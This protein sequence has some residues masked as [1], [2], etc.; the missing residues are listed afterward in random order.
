MTR[1]RFTTFAAGAVVAAL[2]ALPVGA[3]AAG[4]SAS[5][6]DHTPAIAS[7]AKRTVEQRTTSLGKV[8]VNSEGR[9]LYLFKKD[10]RGKSACSGEC[11]KFW[12]PLRVSGKP[13]AGAGISASKLGTIRRSDGRPQV[14]YNGHPL[15]TF[16]QDTKA[17]QTHGEGL[18]AFGARWFVLSSAGNQISHK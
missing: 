2:S 9:T 7:V 3:F 14:T 10:S 16:M 8:L 5:A 15:Y 18:T 6:A 11:A 1:S 12:P 17:G 4:K 13:T